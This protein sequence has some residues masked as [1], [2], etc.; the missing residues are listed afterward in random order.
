MS[1][2]LLLCLPALL[3]P[4]DGK[5][6][7]RDFKRYF[8]KITETW[9]RVEA[10][11]ALEQ[12][13]DPQVARLLVPVLRDKDRRVADAAIEVLGQLPSETA[14]QPLREVLAKSSDRREVSGVLRAVSRGGWKEFAPLVR[15]QFEN[16]EAGVRVWAATAAARLKDAEALPALAEM[17]REDDNDLVRVAAV[18]ALGALGKGREEAAGPP[19]VAAL[20][21]PALEVQTAACLALH[22]VR[23]K[24]A[25][26]VLIDLLEN[27]KGRILEQ[28]YPALIA[29]TD[30]QFVDDPAL[31]R[32]WWA[33]AGDS[34]RVP[35]EA[36][37]AKRR[38]AR[39]KA[40]AQYRPSQSEASFMGIDTTS[41]RVVFIIDVS[42]S[43]QDYVVNRDGFKQRGFTRFGKLDIVKE[44]LLRTVQ[45]LDTSV[46]FNILSFA[47]KVRPWKKRLV[48]ANALN[49]RSAAAW[50]RKLKPIGGSSA[51]GLASAGLSGSSGLEEGRTNT[52][53]AL[54]AGLGVTGGEDP[55]A[56]VKSDLDTVFFLSDGRPSVG[57][58]VDPDDIL[59]AITGLNRFRRVTLHTIAIGEFQK[60]FM[61]DLARQN[62]GM[63]VDLGG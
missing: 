22:K 17:A 1:L 27:G 57:E 18:D 23:V 12:I 7:I 6:T 8:R 10:V 15:E 47:T 36:E 35:T 33:K 54:L 61:T 38:V 24:E 58:L 25:V 40:N 9:E 53:A 14:R 28:V 60:D 46:S 56:K 59:E 16:G 63:F 51:R 34:Y 19:L 48:Q 50:V 11:K 5:D 62:G 2:A 3:S 4:Q 45:N 52:Y 41:T 44:E 32:R 13:D 30:L 39:R 37:I 43:M 55:A 26:P 29:V 20:N 42:G 49:R 31:W 21:D